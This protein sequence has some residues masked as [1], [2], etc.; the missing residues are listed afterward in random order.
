MEAMSVFVLFAV[1]V[2]AIVIGNW[3]LTNQRRKSLLAWAQAHGLAFEAERRYD[4]ESRY[5]DLECLRRGSNRYA[6]NTLAGAWKAHRFTG[7]DYHYETYGTD[8]KG[9]RQTQNHYFSAVVLESRVPLKPLVI[10]PERFFDKVAEFF[11]FDDIDFESAEFSRKF[12]VKAPDKKWAYAV[13]HP[14]TME[15]LMAAPV[16]PLQFGARGVI[17]YRDTTFRPTEFEQAAELVAGILDRL[18]P[19]VEQELRDEAQGVAADAPQG[20]TA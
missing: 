20:V 1:V 7:F 10:R 17:A 13:I 6:Y 19:Y 8:S 12:Y 3:Y 5:P 4:L 11:G 9:R 15:F 16:F 18:P 2:V 14:R